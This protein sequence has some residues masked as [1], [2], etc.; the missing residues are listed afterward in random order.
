MNDLD[1]RTKIKRQIK[2]SE[3]KYEQIN[4]LGDRNELS[5]TI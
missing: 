4:K 1:L 5:N 3:S 2:Y